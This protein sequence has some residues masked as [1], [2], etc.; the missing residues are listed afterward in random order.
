MWLATVP[1]S[2]RAAVELPPRCG[3]QRVATDA[4]AQEAEPAIA[5]S[6]LISAASTSTCTVIHGAVGACRTRGRC[7]CESV[8]KIAK[9]PLTIV[10]TQLF[11]N[12][13]KYKY[14]PRTAID[15]GLGPNLEHLVQFIWDPRFRYDERPR[16][17]L[18]KDEIDAPS[19]RVQPWAQ[20]V[21]FPRDR[22][23][24]KTGRFALRT[25]PSNLEHSVSD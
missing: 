5:G 17:Q 12:C 24:L 2:L 7:F 20:P 22:G 25:G 11:R 13:I 18:R 8:W 14:V 19:H 1:G 21:L 4:G 3:G 10:L 15:V 6:F 23:V 16:A 9:N